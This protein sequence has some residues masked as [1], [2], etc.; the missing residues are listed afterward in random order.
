MAQENIIGERA[1]NVYQENGRTIVRYHATEVVR[2]DNETIILDSGGW[3]TQTTKNRMNQTSGQFNL[4]FRVVQ[5]SFAW[6]VNFKGEIIEF[7]DNLELR[8]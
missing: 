5:K 7:T 8:R 1:T 6:Y 4:G 3:K 2:F